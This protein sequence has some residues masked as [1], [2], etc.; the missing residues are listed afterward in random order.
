[1]KRVF[2]LSPANSGGER[3]RLLY[4]PEARFELAMKLRTPKGARTG[5]VFA[6][7]S[8]L[9]FRGKLSYARAFAQPPRGVE[10]ALVITTDRGL[11]SAGQ[12]VTV[13]E[14]RRV[15]GVPIDLR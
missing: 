12:D 5:E 3:A 9:Y 14:L 6:F 8:G 7:L 4:R 1:M 13:D 15:G 11:V 2:V 10:E